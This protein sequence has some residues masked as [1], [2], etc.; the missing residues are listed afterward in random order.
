MTNLCF[1]LVSLDDLE[2]VPEGFPLELEAWSPWEPEGYLEEPM[3]P[4]VEE[5]GPGMED[6]G[7][8]RSKKAA[9]SG[10]GPL[11]GGGARALLPRTQPL[12]V[13]TDHLAKY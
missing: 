13:S 10:R 8:V 11:G 4:P 9:R 5:G 12:A 6:Y 2:S 7:E 3:E 1:Q